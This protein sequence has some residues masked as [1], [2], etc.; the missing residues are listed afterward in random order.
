M[1][2]A[3]QHRHRSGP[4]RALKPAFNVPGDPHARNI[5]FNRSIRKAFFVR[6]FSAHNGPRQ[7]TVPSFA[8]RLT[9][10]S[11]GVFD[12]LRRRTRKS[13]SGSPFDNWC[14]RRNRSWI[15]SRRCWS[16]CYGG[17]LQPG[18]GKKIATLTERMMPGKGIMCGET[19]YSRWRAFVV[20]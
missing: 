20:Q 14:S 9:R 2:R 5:R 16:R 17:S 7:R 10:N 15:K 8:I 19:G 13:E 3:G 12:C 18:E 1:P 11:M 6:V 4:T